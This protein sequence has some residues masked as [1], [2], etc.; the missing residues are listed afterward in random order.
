MSDLTRFTQILRYGQVLDYLK[1]AGGINPREGRK[2]IA[3]GIIR[4]RQLRAHGRKIY[5]RAQI[6]RDVLTEP[7]EGPASTAKA[8]VRRKN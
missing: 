7:A 2:L 3:F 4:G 5:Y 1:A 6:D 8:E